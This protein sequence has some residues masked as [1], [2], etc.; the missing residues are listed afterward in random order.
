MKEMMKRSLAM[1]CAVVL[2]VTMLPIPASAAA[3]NPLANGW[4][5][6]VSGN[7]ADRVLDIHDN[8]KVNG[9]NLETYT[10]NNTT[11][12]RFYLQYLNNGYY[13]I[14]V[15][16]SGKYLHKSGSGENV[17]QWDGYGSFNAQWA[18]ESAG[19]GYYYLR[20]RNGNYMDN[21]GGRTT[22]GNNVITY[23][24]N[25]SAAQKWKFLSTSTTANEKRSLADGWYMIESGNS[26]DRVLDIHNWSM[27][28]AGNL[29]TY[30]KNQTANQIF[31][32]QYRS[33]IRYYTIRALHSGKY[34]HKS[35]S[36]EN[37]HQWDGYGSFNAQWALEPAGGGYYYLRCKNGN[38]M[39]N[40]NGSTKLSNNVITYN[41][42]GTAAQK[43]KFVRVTPPA[44]T[45]SIG[46]GRYDP[47]ELTQGQSYSISGTVNCNYQMT[48][49]TAGVYYTNGSPTS[50]V[51]SATPNSWTYDIKGLDSS[52][53]F[54]A[55]SAG[56]YRFRV[57]ATTAAMGSKTVVDKSFTVKA[58]SNPVRTTIGSG[59]YAPGTLTKGQSYSISGTVSSNYTLTNVTAGVYYT[60][61]TPTAQV[62]S[63]NPRSKSYNISGLDS[64]IRFGALAAGTYKFIVKATANGT[65]TTLV[66]N[67]FNVT[68]PDKNARTIA[69]KTHEV[70]GRQMCILTSIS[71]LV[72]SR[73]YLDGKS[74]SHIT[75]N[76]VK[77]WNNNALLANW[78]LICKNAN[79][80]SGASKTL[81]NVDR[82]G[83]SASANQQ[84][85]IDLLKSRPEGVVVYF[86]KDVNNQHAVRFCNY[87][88]KTK[89]FY[90]SD[91]GR[92]TYKYVSLQTSLIGNGS[93]S[94]GSNCW[95]SVK[96][97]QVVYYK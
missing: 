9:G 50:Q 80:K 63:A 4:Y 34:L 66:T 44:M 61:N 94:W 20:C 91:P 59:R 93:Y 77:S 37:V 13:S 41:F 16:H 43:W 19:N 31:Y 10:K 96:Q 1:L 74:Y 40:S 95:G 82:S 97:I 78:N 67:T 69:E 51:K 27:S 47:K 55:L 35:G 87:D 68:E 79:A 15:L 52:I 49:I 53:R 64:R 3:K 92:S 28:N 85:V 14:K 72:K 12:Q 18:L 58:K 86:R 25:G 56:T 57:I 89:T 6:I 38:Y 8:S 22:P 90:V 88:A 48:N 11:N 21:S 5:M 84:F 42:N 65:E 75:Q 29:E 2:V 26:S 17:H 71:M 7:S 36:E 60:N 83:Y 23:R 32:V 62:A 45:A 39:D 24:F 30:K 73:L 81:T 33:D 70:Q 76:T 54:G 46:P